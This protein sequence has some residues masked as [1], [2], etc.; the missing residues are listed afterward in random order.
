MKTLTKTL[1]IAAAMTM[2]A[3]GG[4]YAADQAMDCCAK[5]ECCKDKDKDKKPDAST[6]TAQPHDHG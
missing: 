5:C 4:A 3:A 1:A 6:D 2:F